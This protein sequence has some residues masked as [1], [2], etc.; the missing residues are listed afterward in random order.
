VERAQG[1]VGAGPSLAGVQGDR[2]IKAS[3]LDRPPKYIYTYIGNRYYW[4]ISK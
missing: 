3:N 4:P 2:S 1:H